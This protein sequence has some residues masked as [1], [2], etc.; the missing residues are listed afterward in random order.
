[1]T[2]LKTKVQF[3]PRDVKAYKKDIDHLINFIEQSVSNPKDYGRV[4]DKAKD[5]LKSGVLPGLTQN[6]IDYSKM[7]QSLQAQGKINYSS[8]L[9]VSGTLVNDLEFQTGDITPSLTYNYI[10]FSNVPKSRPTLESMKKAY[11]NP[12][13]SIEYTSISTYEIVKK[14]EYSTGSRQ[15]FQIIESLYNAYARDMLQTLEGIVDYA[16]A[17]SRER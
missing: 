12:N 2:K 1:M 5:G 13:Y 11:K 6:N 9:A 14:L 17:R 10:T 4:I 16:F 8:L 7:K 3:D 15:D